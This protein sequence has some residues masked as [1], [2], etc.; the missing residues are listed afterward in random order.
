MHPVHKTIHKI[1]RISMAALVLSCLV[2]IGLSMVAKTQRALADQV[3]IRS[4]KM[5]D[6]IASDTGVKYSASFNISNAYG[7]NMKSYII[8]FCQESPLPGDICTAPAGL[9]FS[10]A[11]ASGGDTSTWTIATT[12]SQIKASDP[13]GIA[14]GSNVTLELSGVTNSSVVG[15]FYARIYTFNNDTFGTYSGPTAPGNYV[16][17]GGD[18][19][20]TSNTLA[21]NA[22]VQEEI[23]FCVSGALMGNGCSGETPANLVIGHG[24]PPIV[25]GS[26][27][28]TAAAYMQTTTNASN[29]AA[30]RM[31]SSNNCGG[32]SSDGGLTC[33]VPPAG[34]S[35]I[36]FNPGTADFGAN[37]APS[38]GGIGVV[39]PT[40]PYNQNT[41]NKFA[42][43]MT[44]GTGVTSTYGSQIADSGTGCSNVNNAIIF[45]AAASNI[46]A[47]DT[48]NATLELIA[49]GTY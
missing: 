3:T 39:T 32:L 22:Y 49:T 15:T 7:G 12:A 28:D 19:L 16:D 42:M 25:D 21:L 6:S 24:I 18:A 13:T 41:S 9:D 45:A 30:I 33:P 20:S 31:K 38:S 4:I 23:T 46:T 10:S 48:Y 40:S 35:A 47:A 8:D 44:P 26:Q 14:G 43:V 5:S 27:V 1:H 37:V 36:T 11:V 29:G 2:A 17:F 34:N